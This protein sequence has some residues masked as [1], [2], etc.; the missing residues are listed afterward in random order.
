MKT[1]LS[2]LASTL[3]IAMFF[4]CGESSK[5]ID[6]S[7]LSPEPKETSKPKKT[8]LY[9]VINDLNVRDKAGR[10]GTVIAKLKYGQRALY[11]DEETDFKERIIMRGK[12]RFS[13][14]KKIRFS[15]GNGSA[16]IEGWVFGGGMLTEDEQFSKVDTNAFER[17]LENVTREEF[18][19][20]IGMTFSPDFVFNGT[21]SYSRKN[22][23]ENGAFL[24]NGSFRVFGLPIDRTNEMKN[25]N[26]EY[27]GNFEDGK[28]EGE[29]KKKFNGYESESEAI[30]YFKNGKC[31][32][33]ELKGQAEGEILDKK[34]DSPEKCNFQFLE[35]QIVVE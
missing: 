8:I 35:S 14:W 4:G 32:W 26:V 24:K 27:S 9:S 25:V 29:F 11:L 3:I 15:L 12:E 22:N 5:E 23:S 34:I 20:V 30:I 17:K 19:Q 6:D 31:E 2:F 13:S 28:A 16:A 7:Q 21:V 10:K 18:S 1:P 33:S